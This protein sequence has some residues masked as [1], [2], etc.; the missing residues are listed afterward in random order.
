MRKYCWGG[1]LKTGTSTNGTFVH[2]LYRIL[3]LSSS[4]LLIWLCRFLFNAR[5]HHVSIVLGYSGKIHELVNMDAV[6]RC[7][8][9]YWDALFPSTLRVRNFFY[10]SIRV[11]PR[12]LSLKR[13]CIPFNIFLMVSL[14]TKHQLICHTLPMVFIRDKVSLIR[15]YTGGGTVVVDENT[16]KQWITLIA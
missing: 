11:P 3:T 8:Q 1:A 9:H 5:S 16:G 15:R 13:K 14:W 7:G 6:H 12:N 2:K 10:V 4:F